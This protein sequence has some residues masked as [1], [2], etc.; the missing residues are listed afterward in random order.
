M[1]F[2]YEYRTRNNER[3]SGEISAPDRESVFNILKK[4]GIRPGRVIEVP[5]FLNKILGKGKRWI[6][7]VSLSVL[8]V[9]TM[10]FSIQARKERTL[11]AHELPR[12]QIYGDPAIMAEMESSGYSQVF[13]H[14][15]ERFLA[16]YAIPGIETYIPKEYMVTDNMLEDALSNRI[17]FRKDDPREWRDLKAIVN[18]MKAEMQEYLSDKVG[19]I[20]SFR[21][22]L[23]ERQE[24]ELQIYRRAL[25]ELKNNHDEKLRAERNKSLRAIGLRTIPIRRP[26]NR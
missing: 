3:K 24:E 22:R 1:K 8:S 16:H 9:A 4:Q 2:I 5:G 10:L 12:H 11:I 7:I 15:G 13:T 26:A 18:G 21:L 19:T 14:P 23:N 20:K 6:A 25:N 17:E